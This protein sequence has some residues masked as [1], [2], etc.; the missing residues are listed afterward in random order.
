MPHCNSE[1]MGLH[2]EE[3]AFHVAPSAHAVILL[4]QAGWHGSND[5][6]IPSTPPGVRRCLWCMIFR[7]RVISAVQYLPSLHLDRSNT[8]D[9]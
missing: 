1:A 9:P 8:L 7:Y 6:I 2:L 5:L 4:D 3:I